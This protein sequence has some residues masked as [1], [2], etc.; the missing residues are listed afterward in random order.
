MTRFKEGQEL[1]TRSICDHNCIFTAVVVKRT[2]KTVT[3]AD[4]MRGTRRCKIHIDD[5][6]CEY[7]F[8][9]GKYS[10]ASIYRAK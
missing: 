5:D 4:D 10:M 7:I 2:A 9:H 8:P 1:A 3:I 6:G